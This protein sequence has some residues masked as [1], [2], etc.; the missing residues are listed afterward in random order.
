MEN[1]I[2]VKQKN[3]NKIFLINKGYLNEIH[4]KVISLIGNGGFGAVFKGKMIKIDKK[5]SEIIDNTQKF[6]IKVLYPVFRGE[7]FV[8]ESYALKILANEKYFAQFIH[9]FIYDNKINFVFE[10]FKSDNFNVL[11]NKFLIKN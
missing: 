5:G 1:Q 6:A 9:G 11:I 2:L 3:I 4:L 7:V 10:Y 8:M